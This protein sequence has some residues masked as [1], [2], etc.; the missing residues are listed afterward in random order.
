M[1][2]PR[3]GARSLKPA[4]FTAFGHTAVAR[5]GAA[6]LALF[7]CAAAVAALAAPNSIGLVS[8][9][10]DFQT[11]APYAILLD[12]ETGTVLFEKNAD[13]PNP[14]SSVDKLL[15]KEVIFTELKQK[16]LKL[17]DE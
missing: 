15:T 5:I 16:R 6:T 12:A 17:V 11:A 14:P 8:G 3:R 2:A 1:E 13:V 4:R 9:K 10:S 7:V